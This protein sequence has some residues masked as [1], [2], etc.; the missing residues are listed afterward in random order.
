MNMSYFEQHKHNLHITRR[1]FCLFVASL[2]K[3]INRSAPTTVI[4]VV[5][6]QKDVTGFQN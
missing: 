5:Q 3:T 6:N 4:C 1:E 2:I